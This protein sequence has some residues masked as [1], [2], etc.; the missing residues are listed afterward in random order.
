MSTLR[1]Q[2]PKPH[3]AQQEVLAAA[4]R[5]NV[6]DC[7]RRWGKTQLGIDRCL[8]VALQSKPAAWYAPKYKDLAMVWRELKMRCASIITKANEQER[9]LEL[10]GGGAI[11]MWSLDSADS[12]RG[13]A[14]ALA[15]LDEAAIVPNLEQAW[16][17]SIRPQLS[18]YQ[19]SAWF[20]STPKGIAN[21]Y[22]TL[23]LRGQYDPEWVSWQMPTCTNPYIKPCEIEAAHE[24]LS[25][26]AF[27]QEYLAQFVSWEGSVFRKILDAVMAQ[28]PTGNAAVIGVDWGRTNDYTA[29]IVVSDAGELLEIDRFRGMEYSLQRG[30][31]AALY[32]KHGKPPILAESNSMG[33][34]VIEQLQRDGLKVKAFNTTNLSKA[35]A[36]EALALAFERGEIHIP[37]DPVLIGELQAFE[38]HALPSGLMRYEA[39]A[40][41]HDDCVMALAIAWHGIVKRGAKVFP[42]MSVSR[43]DFG[44][45]TDGSTQKASAAGRAWKF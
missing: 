40:N 3:P 28:P 11:D 41:G 30:R 45:L 15:I 44:H 1:V 26:L 33:G 32:D 7:G 19:G 8:N 25:E 14:Y 10:I 42:I 20:L 24:D 29:F 31:L 23:Y 22:H 5:F 4:K 27:A 17:Q 39:A 16:Q 38:G 13:R 35:E 9:R 12:G 36:V 6:V 34:P 43:S 18:D 2:L 37:N 21:Y